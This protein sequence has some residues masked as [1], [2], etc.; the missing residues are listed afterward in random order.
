MYQHHKYMI[1]KMMFCQNFLY[2]Y[3][4]VRLVKGGVLEYNHSMKESFFSPE[5]RQFA[6]KVCIILGIMAVV[7]V[8]YTLQSIIVMFGG[9]VFIALLLSPFVS[10]FSRWHIGKWR[11]PDSMAIF[12]SFGV[13]FG[14]I[15][16][17]VLAIVPIF[18]DLGNNTKQSLERGV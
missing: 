11:V 9:A 4:F 1:S 8:L 3:S 12:L 14:F 18:I 7:W 13:L 16:L 5:T 15:S 17:F 2:H 10:Y 6:L